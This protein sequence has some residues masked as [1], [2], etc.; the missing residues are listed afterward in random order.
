[1]SNKIRL[2]LVFFLII[3]IKNAYS[4]N[5]AFIDM[6]QILSK[7]KIGIYINNEIEKK[8]NLSQKILKEMEED[9]RSKD[10]K[11]NSQKNILSDNELKK[12]ID[13]LNEDLKNYQK[14]TQE[15]RN[16]INS[17]QIS[18]TGKLLKNLKPILAEYS[19]DKNISIIF[20]KK[21]L[22]IAKNSLNITK[23]IIKILDQKVEKIDL[24]E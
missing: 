12:K 9:L 15:S 8:N 22:I 10:N 11:I 17:F 21:D 5:L 2:Y 23:D 16:K 7:S 3:S 14:I 13:E 6:D 20:Q 19:K 1:M 4:E 18:A 24:D